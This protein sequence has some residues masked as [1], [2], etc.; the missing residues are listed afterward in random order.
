M[1]NA[2]TAAFASDRLMELVGRLK[3]HA[4]FAEVVASL[5]AG[6][7]AT[8]DGVWGSSC[9]LAAAILAKHAPASLVVICAQVDEVDDLADDLSLFTPIV[10][11]RFPACERLPNEAAEGG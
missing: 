10:P 7:A 9:A 4:G 1:A 6:H 5:L 8:L 3:Q 2:G 11:Q